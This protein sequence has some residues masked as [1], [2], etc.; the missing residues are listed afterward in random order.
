[1]S[2]LP[3]VS[4]VPVAG[5]RSRQPLAQHLTEA[6]KSN[7]RASGCYRTPSCRLRAEVS[8][9]T[10]IDPEKHRP[11][12]LPHNPK[13]LKSQMWATVKHRISREEHPEADTTN[14][15]GPTSP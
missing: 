4:A 5:R 12:M 15:Q 11:R 7:R 10:E 2:Y 3:V 13:A 8:H 1:M 9:L 6:R 14:Q